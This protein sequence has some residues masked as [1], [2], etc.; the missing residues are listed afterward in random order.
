MSLITSVAMVSVIPY[1]HLANQYLRVR[2]SFGYTA[3][4]IMLLCLMLWFFQETLAVVFI[5][6]VLSGPI[7]L[8]NE[9]ARG[10]NG[11]DEDL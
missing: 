1:R 6:Y 3:R 4:V 5:A 11:E 8:F 7:S 10:M 2:R 9:R